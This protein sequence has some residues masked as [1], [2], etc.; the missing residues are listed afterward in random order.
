[1][2]LTHTLA[3]LGLTLLSACK[4]APD[5]GRA[6][7]EGAPALLPLGPD[8]PR[9]DFRSQWA[10]RAEILPALEQSIAWSHKKSSEKFFPIEGVT[11]ERQRASLERF[12]QALVESQSAAEFDARIASDFVVMKSAGWDGRGGGVLYTAYC[13]PIL[14][15]DVDPSPQYRYPLYAKPEDLAKNETTGEILGRRT[16]GGHIEPY[17]TRRTIE[18]G[19][20]LANK[21]LELAWLADPIDAYIAHVN[22]SAF[23]KLRD[24]SMLKLGYAAKNGREYTSLGAELVK[25]KKLSKDKVSLRSIREWAKAHPNEVQQYLDRNESYVFFTPI[26][27]TPHGSL[28]V[29]VSANRSL[30]T[31]K[32][33]FPR[34]SIVFVEGRPDSGLA[35]GAHVDHFMFD[36]DTGGAIRTAGRADIYLGTGPEAEARSGATRVEG[37]L[38]YLFVKDSLVEP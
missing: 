19:H 14:E 34:G 38:Y 12:K 36:Q 35:D 26:D 11:I 17:P 32:R 4:S 15:G 24:G 33:L 16:V 30:A 3:V 23:V 6:L 9:P 13:T 28:N 18:A 22:G 29:P 1:M 7:P 8:E 27:G 2:K 5:Y 37:Q 10:A 25:D 21:E 31:D 20:L